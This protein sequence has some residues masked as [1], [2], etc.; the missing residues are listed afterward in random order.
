MEDKDNKLINI[1]EKSSSFFSLKEEKVIFCNNFCR[2]KLALILKKNSQGRLIMNK[3]SNGV[4]D[5]ITAVKKLEWIRSLCKG[6]GEYSSSLFYYA[7]IDIEYVIIKL[8]LIWDYIPHFI[9]VLLEGS[10]KNNLNATS[11]NKFLQNISNYKIDSKLKQTIELV[12]KHFENIKE[13]RDKIVH[14]G[15]E[16]VVF[17]VPSESILFQIQDPKLSSEFKERPT[18]VS[19]DE[20]EKYNKIFS[21]ENILFEPLLMNEE[22]KNMVDFSK[23]ISFQLSYLFNL[24]DELSKIISEL[25]NINLQEHL[26]DSYQVH[27]YDIIWVWLKNFLEQL[28]KPLKSI[29]GDRTYLF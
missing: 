6:N 26:Y 23:Y 19:S 12:K 4:L 24:L 21:S 27:G 1:L 16:I 22:Y 2:F 20:L 15:G 7:R 13:I 9:K 28:K 8:R 5:I 29:R 11:F 10:K 17:L 18:N 3:I 25:I 14:C